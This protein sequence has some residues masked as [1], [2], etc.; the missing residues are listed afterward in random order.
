MTGVPPASPHRPIPCASC[1]ARPIP[2]GHAR[3]PGRTLLH[4]HAP[5]A[6]L[7]PLAAPA[8]GGTGSAVPVAATGKQGPLLL[9]TTCAQCPPPDTRQIP[10]AA[11]AGKPGKARPPRSCAEDGRREYAAPDILP[12]THARPVA[13]SPAGSGRRATGPAG[14]GN[15]KRAP[16]PHRQAADEVSHTERST[17]TVH[18][19]HMHTGRR[20]A[21]LSATTVHHDLAHLLSVCGFRISFAPD[22]WIWQR[23]WPQ[24]KSS[25]SSVGGLVGRL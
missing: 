18:G 23:R 16:K 5:A 10:G 19:G 9:R 12:H 2:R 6:G 7:D 24:R 13:R 14:T 1:R 4:L 3:R 11:A 25:H 20:R 17:T 21:P 15:A 22:G 8:A